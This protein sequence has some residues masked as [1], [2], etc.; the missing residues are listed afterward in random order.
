MN[1]IDKM[2]KA[3]KNVKVFLDSTLDDKIDILRECKKAINVKELLKVLTI[4]EVEEF[5]QDI[6]DSKRIKS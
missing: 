2:I 5:L 4:N 3:S 6:E 1:K